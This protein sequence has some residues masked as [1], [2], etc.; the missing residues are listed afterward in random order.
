MPGV[1]DKDDILDQI[2]VIPED[3]CHRR[4][5]VS[6]FPHCHFTHGGIVWPGLTISKCIP[7]SCHVFYHMHD[8]LALSVLS[9]Y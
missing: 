5:N 3:N 2:V 6:S 4:S 1:Q 8:Q 9:D 7:Y